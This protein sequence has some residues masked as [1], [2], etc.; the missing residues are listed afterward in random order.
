MIRTKMLKVKRRVPGLA[1]D[2]N[3]EIG[4]EPL[5]PNSGVENCSFVARVG[6]NNQNAVGLLDNPKS[7]S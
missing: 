3:L 6:S 2:A 4:S 7:W 1:D 5:L